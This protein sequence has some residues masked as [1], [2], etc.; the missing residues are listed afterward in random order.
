MYSFPQ[1]PP[2]TYTTSATPWRRSSEADHLERGALGLLSAVFRV[3]ARLRHGGPGAGEP[4][5]QAAWARIEA[6]LA[7]CIADVEAISDALAKQ[8]RRPEP[9]EG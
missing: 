8:G 1:F 5:E 4:F 3:A 2:T 9:D 7:A 6:R